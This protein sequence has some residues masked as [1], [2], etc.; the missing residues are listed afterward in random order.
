VLL[1]GL[2]AAVSLSAGIWATGILGF[3]AAAVFAV[4]IP[5][6]KHRRNY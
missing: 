2:T 5:R 3:A 4:A 1:S 6:L